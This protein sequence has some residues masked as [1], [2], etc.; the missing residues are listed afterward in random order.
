MR[1][2]G[3]QGDP[4][5]QGS[6]R[7]A[8][9]I[10]RKLLALSAFVFLVFGAMVA[11]VS[12]SFR[13]IEGLLATTVVRDVNHNVENAGLLRE[14]SAVF[15]EANLL[16]STFFRNGGTFA[17]RTRHLLAATAELERRST[18]DPL[19]ASLME[20]SAELRRLFDQCAE[21]NRILADA[22]AHSQSLH[23]HL[24]ALEKAVSR[25]KIDQILA[26]ED[27][28]FMEQLSVLISG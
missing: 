19:K 9:G 16:A 4:A 13:N 3:G 5:P 27:P 26:G 8:F 21:V 14:L 6:R 7:F 22:D 1:S 18:D 12:V 2:P 15:A 20:F 24:D 11:V 25:K 28:T 10:S 17:A 23:A